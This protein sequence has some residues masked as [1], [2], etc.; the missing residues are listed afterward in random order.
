MPPPWVPTESDGFF[1]RKGE[2]ILFSSAYL[3]VPHA[4]YACSVQ[5]PWGRQNPEPEDALRTPFQ[6][7]RHRIL[8]TTS[9]RRL[10]HKTQ[11]F[12]LESGDHFRTRLTHTLEVAQIARSIA[13][14]LGLDEDLTEAIALAHDLGHP[15]F[16]HQGEVVLQACMAPF[17]GFEHNAQSLRL[18]TMLERRYAGFDGLNLTY[19]T[20]EGI[21]K[22]NGPLQGKVLPHAFEAYTGL[23]YLHPS[24]QASAEGQTAALA[25]EIAYNAHDLDDGLRAGLFTLE[26]LKPIPLLG[27]MIEEVDFCCSGLEERRRIH[28]VIRRLVACVERDVVIESAQRL[29]ALASP[30]PESVREAERPVIAFS[31]EMATHITL[32]KAFLSERMYH[33]SNVLQSQELVAAVIRG[34]F[35]AFTEQFELMPDEWSATLVDLFAREESVLAHHAEPIESVARARHVCDY[36]AGMTDRYALDVYTRLFDLPKKF[37]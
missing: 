27:A 23:S 16:G 32:I 18:V 37:R 3:S 21:L 1:L 13:R 15:P 35:K 14:Y 20:L 8:H 22:H 34:L 2:G 17:G 29:A 4:P 33:H 36:I 28:E 7:D 11:V 31:E 19:E 5:A 10:E 26:A 25:D 12:V 9:F 24:L 30:S 6:R